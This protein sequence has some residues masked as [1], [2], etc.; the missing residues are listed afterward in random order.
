LDKFAQ[1]IITL[2]PPK[3]II[4]E[5]A[6]SEIVPPIERI[7]S[8]TFKSKG[9]LLEALTAAGANEDNHEGNRRFSHVGLGIIHTVLSLECLE[10]KSSPG[11]LYDLRIPLE[12]ALTSCGR[13]WGA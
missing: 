4:C 12:V 5:M 3:L 7:L 8:Y 11:K 2:L 10:R 6:T 9:L 1:V 13:S